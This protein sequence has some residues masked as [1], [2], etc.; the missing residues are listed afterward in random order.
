M[1][2][3]WKKKFSYQNDVLHAIQHDMNFLNYL[4]APTPKTTTA[5]ATALPKSSSLFNV[6]PKTYSDNDNTQHKRQCLSP[7]LIS[8]M[9]NDPHSNNTY[10]PSHNSY[11]H[12]LST[13][14]HDMYSI[15]D[16]IMRS[17]RM[18]MLSFRKDNNHNSDRDIKLFLEEY[19]SKNSLEK[20]FNEI[21]QRDKEENNHYTKNRHM[22][23]KVNGNNGVRHKDKKNIFNSVLYTKILP[24]RKEVT[25][26]DESAVNG[27]GKECLRRY[28]SE[29]SYFGLTNDNVKHTLQIEIPNKITRNNFSSCKPNN[30]RLQNELEPSQRLEFI[31]K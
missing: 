18:R 6:F 4:G 22:F 30:T 29:K 19:K 11:Y 23:I 31:H 26:R 5:T 25:K 24:Q 7:L 15:K 1:P 13:S 3:V 2:N 16:A 14:H 20:K 12:K 9:Q 28:N 17:N 8:T 27:E 10:T 21:W